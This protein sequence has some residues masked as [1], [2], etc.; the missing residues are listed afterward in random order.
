MLHTHLQIALRRLRRQKGYAAI[1]VLGLAVGLAVCGVLLLF[2]RH[3][4]SYEAFHEKADRIHLLIEHSE[5]MG[6][7]QPSTSLTSPLA[8]A[9]RESLPEVERA[10]RVMGVWPTPR[11]RVG[12]EVHYPQGDFFLA[13]ASIFDVFTFPLLAGDPA[14]ALSEPATVVIGQELAAHLFGSSPPE[15]IVGETIEIG[16]GHHRVTGVMARVPFTTHWRPA[17]LLPL[18]PRLN[19]PNDWLSDPTGGFF[20]TYLLFREGSDPA[21]ALAKAPAALAARFEGNRHAE[22][23]FSTQPISRIHLHGYEEGSFPGLVSGLLG[24][25]VTRLW[26]FVGVAL[27]ILLLASVNYVNLATAYG[28]QRTREVG[29]RKTL[30]ARRAHI[31]AQSLAESTLLAG[32]AGAIAV[33]LV[34]LALPHFNDAVQTSI[35]FSLWQEPHLVAAFL[36]VATSVGLLAGAYP[37]LVLS[38]ARPAEA[39]RGHAPSGLSG[40]RV[41]QVLVVFQFAVTIALIGCTLVMARQLAF[42]QTE[43]L[44]LQPEQVLAV[45]LR[46]A[47]PEARTE[48]FEQALRRRPA[49]LE[50]AF[51]SYT[52]GLSGPGYGSHRRDTDAGPTHVFV[53]QFDV[54]ASFSSVM[55]MEIIAGG[56]LPDPPFP[57]PAPILINES[58]AAEAGWRPEEAIGRE[59]PLPGGHP[60]VGVVRDFHY[61][62][63]RAAVEPAMIR[64]LQPRSRR[65]ELLVRFA[66]AETASV[67]DAVRAAWAEVAPGEPLRYHFLDETFAA[68]YSAERRLAGLFGAFAMLA[69]LVACLGLF[70]LAAFTSERRTREI[71]IR[72]ALGASAASVVALLS[73]DFVKLVLVAFVVAT[74]PAYYAMS[75]WLEGFAYRVELG[76][77]VFVATGVLALAVAL[78]AV[79]YHALRAASTNPV[80]ALRS[81]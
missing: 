80:E 50:T 20:Q 53:L 6:E 23:T 2:A 79:S 16:G 31:A 36:L 5:M 47:P 45:D 59:Y 68:F 24:L 34:L 40:V 26:I 4:T 49:V 52:P 72:K 58:A 78:A 32:A 69:V 29:V 70:G 46:H 63:M 1:N 66:P 15:E 51:T 56:P 27:L 9:L 38:A 17:A 54:E 43:R 60:V 77:G 12:D 13:D 35:G 81:E 30:G 39:F 57:E 25:N 74:P 41:R 44:G 8:P 10:V 55:G 65:S 37:A 75:R 64:P 7:V 73:K 3:E 14:T 42:M 61:H 18:E 21:A 76:P 11:V 28:L 19:D 67:A 33:G 48:A 22:A 71:G 62:T